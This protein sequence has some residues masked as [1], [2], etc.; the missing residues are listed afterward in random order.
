VDAL[1]KDIAVFRGEAL[2]ANLLASAAMLSV[3]RNRDGILA[4][5]SDEI[6]ANL[7]LSGPDKGDP[8]DELNTLMRE[9]AR[10]QAMQVLD[11]IRLKFS[12]LPI[13]PTKG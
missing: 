12:N 6:D 7:N 10:L 11:M 1:Q 8:H 9:T 5:I 3:S 13:P 2:A 4:M